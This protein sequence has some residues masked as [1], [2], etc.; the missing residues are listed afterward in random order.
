VRAIAKGG[1]AQVLIVEEL[2]RLSRAP[3]GLHVLHRE[4][5]FE[6]VTIETCSG[7]EADHLQVGFRG[8]MGGNNELPL[9]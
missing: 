4:L 1:Q 6:G 3:A 8:L 5:E 9:R 7:V 2:D